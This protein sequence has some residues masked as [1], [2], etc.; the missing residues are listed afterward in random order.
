MKQIVKNYAFN[1]GDFRRKE[2]SVDI[3]TQ[4]NHDLKKNPEWSIKLM[5]YIHDGTVCTVVYDVSTTNK[6]LFE[7]GNEPVSNLNGT[8]NNS[9][10]SDASDSSEED[11]NITVI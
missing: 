3:T 2:K 7:S 6:M 10:G 5:T 11:S 8:T 9:I 1:P 4:I